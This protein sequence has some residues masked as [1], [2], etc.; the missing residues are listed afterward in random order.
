[1]K[2]GIHY[3]GT[4]TSVARVGLTVQQAMGLSVDRWGMESNMTSKPISEIMA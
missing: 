3:A 1:M 2:T 4:G